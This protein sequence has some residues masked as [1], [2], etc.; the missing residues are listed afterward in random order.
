MLDSLIKSFDENGDGVFQFDEF[1]EMINKF[2]P[3]ISENVTFHLFKEALSVSPLSIYNDAIEPYV[4]SHMIYKYKLGGYGVE[5]FSNYLNRR[6]QTYREQ[7]I[8]KKK[9]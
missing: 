5:F 4:I 7:V 6:K 3:T 8:N 2:E 1:K 9:V